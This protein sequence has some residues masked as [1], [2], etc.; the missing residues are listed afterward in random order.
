M[1]DKNLNTQRKYIK[2][3]INGQLKLFK[4]KGKYSNELTLSLPKVDSVDKSLVKNILKEI[5]GY[6][7][8]II[9]F[10]KIEH[11]D[12]MLIAIVLK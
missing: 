7:P 4:I 11:L 1:S 12:I 8:I 5:L 2:N 6:D 10:Q 9:S 3:L